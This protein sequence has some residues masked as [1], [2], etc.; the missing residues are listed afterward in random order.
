VAFSFLTFRAHPEELQFVSNS[1]ES[2]A[3]SNLLLKFVDQA[4]LKL[5]DPGATLAD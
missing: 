3:A 4:F 1:A 5:Y 2:M